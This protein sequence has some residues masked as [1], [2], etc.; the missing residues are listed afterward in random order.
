MT[1]KPKLDNL[2]NSVWRLFITANVKLLDRMGE[3]FSQAGLPSMDWYDVLLT[4]KEAPEYRLRLSD[5]AQKALLSRS[6]LTHLVDR[7][8]KAGLLY[9]KRCPSD[10]RGTYAVLTEAGLAMQQQ[11][12]TVYAEGI[13]E[14]FACHLDDE[15]LQV[16]QQ[17]L[18]RML[19]AVSQ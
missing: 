19:A 11:M 9:R 17:V 13:A 4:L 5:L 10:R 14:Y 1:A 6:N 7:L 8:E 15:E 2:R 16:M 18:K 12:W 3:K